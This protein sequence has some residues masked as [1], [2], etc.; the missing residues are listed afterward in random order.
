MLRLYPHHG[1]QCWMII[2]AFY[3]GVAQ[4]VRSTIDVAVGG[5]LIN[6]T[7]DEPYNLIGETTLNNFQ[8][9]TKRGNPN[10]L[11]VRLALMRLLCIL[12]KWML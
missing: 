9:S 7:K 10:E 8:L 6:K 3:N 5:T 2:Q 11:E 1:L 12:L 4:S